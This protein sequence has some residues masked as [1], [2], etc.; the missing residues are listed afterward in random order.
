MTGDLVR[1]VVPMGTIQGVSYN[2]CRPIYR[3]DGYDSHSQ[4][5][6][7]IPPTA[8]PAGILPYKA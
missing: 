6:G 4:K 2:Y 7:G 3:C 1:A 8:E 5:G